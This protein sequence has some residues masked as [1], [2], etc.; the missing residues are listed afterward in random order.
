[1][2]PASFQDV[3]DWF[4]DQTGQRAYIEV[5]LADA[6]ADQQADTPLIRLHTTLG[7]FQD[8]DDAVHGRRF[9]W[10]RFGPEDDRAGLHLDEARFDR[11]A[12]HGGV[13]KVWQH[14]VYVAVSVGVAV[15]GSA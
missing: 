4:A 2:V 11:A 5:G 9:A 14:D 6:Q 10:F 7:G 8:A 1:M 15:D 13:L 3:F 12:I